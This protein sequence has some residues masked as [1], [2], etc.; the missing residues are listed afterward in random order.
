M[1]DRFRM[2]DSGYA[3]VM[4]IVRWLRSVARHRAAASDTAAKGPA[5]TSGI[6][7]GCLGEDPAVAAA[8]V[9]RFEE[10]RSE[11]SPSQ[12]IPY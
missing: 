10:Q 8:R 1:P 4:R 5:P 7:I 11:T 3:L 6:G 12:R 9:Q 2:P